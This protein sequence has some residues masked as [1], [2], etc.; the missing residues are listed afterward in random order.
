M[1]FVPLLTANIRQ[2][3]RFS[4]KVVLCWLKLDKSP[5]DNFGVGNCDYV[6]MSLHRLTCATLRLMTLLLTVS[7]PPASG[8]ISERVLE[9]WFK[10]IWDQQR[11]ECG[12]HLSCQDG[13]S[14]VSNSICCGFCDCEPECMVHGT[15]CL[16]F[17]RNFSHGYNSIRHNRWVKYPPPSS[18]MLPLFLWKL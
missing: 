10:T 9:R 16:G 2:W 15:C 7:I 6:T 14:S 11:S 4:R 12:V 18:W 1:Q 3:L 8:E 17:Y 5:G 13:S